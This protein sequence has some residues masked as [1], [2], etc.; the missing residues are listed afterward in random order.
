MAQRLAGFFSEL[1]HTISTQISL[2]A[3]SPE[4]SKTSEITVDATGYAIRLAMR[5]STLTIAPD[6]WSDP[7]LQRALAELHSVVSGCANGVTGVIE[8]H[9]R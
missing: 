8:Q 1:D 9:Y 4:K 2:S 5:D 3:G 7:P 6:G